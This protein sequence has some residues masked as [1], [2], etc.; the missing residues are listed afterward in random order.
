MLNKQPIRQGLLFI[1]SAPAGTG[2]TTLVNLVMNRVPSLTRS[3]SYTTR[4]P[5][6]NEKDGVDYHFIT[7]EKFDEMVKQGSFLEYV[8]LYGYYY[9]TSITGIEQ[10]LLNGYHVILVI[11]T[12]GALQLKDKIDAAYIFV[13]PPST[14]AL[15]KRL[16]GRHTETPEAIKTRLEWNK[17]EFQVIDQYDYIV[18][19]DDLEVACDTIKSI[20]IAEEHRKKYFFK[21]PSTRQL[22]NSL[23]LEGA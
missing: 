13:L 6:N 21:D 8:E 2:K 10:Q 7:N 17:H 1:L 18:I 3:I 16:E 22:I 4:K 5:R 9:G 15:R 11:D 14:E 23:T 19:N 12:Q 20:I